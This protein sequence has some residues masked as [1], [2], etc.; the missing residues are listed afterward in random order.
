MKGGGR[1][2]RKE[3]WGGRKEGEGGVRM[4]GGGRKGRKEGRRVWCENERRREEGKEEECGERRVE[5]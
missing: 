2:G 1:K 4:K 5:E 3:G